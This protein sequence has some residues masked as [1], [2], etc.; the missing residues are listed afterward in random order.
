MS[1]GFWIVAI[2]STALPR[3][4]EKALIMNIYWPFFVNAV[5]FARFVTKRG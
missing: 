2:F 1:N 3:S 4:K 5:T